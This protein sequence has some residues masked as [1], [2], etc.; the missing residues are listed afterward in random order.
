MRKIWLMSVL[1]VMGGVLLA[2]TAC[3]GAEIAEPTK[4]EPAKVEAAGIPTISTSVSIVTLM[5]TFAVTNPNDKQITITDLSYVLYLGEERVGLGKNIVL[6][7]RP[8]GEEGMAYGVERIEPGMAGLTAVQ[9]LVIKYFGHLIKRYIL[10]QTLTTEAESTGLGSNL[11]SVHLDTYLQIVR[12]DA[13]NLEETLT[14]DLV[15]VLKAFNFP[16][17]VDVPLRF[18]IET[19]LADVEAKLAGARQAWDMGCK[20]KEADIMEAI[21]M[22]SPKDDDIVLQDPAAQQAAMGIVPG[23]EGFG[24]NG[25]P[26][27]DD[28]NPTEQ[29]QG[30]GNGMF[31]GFEVPEAKFDAAG[32]PISE[33]S[34]RE[35][36]KRYDEAEAVETAENMA[37]YRND[38]R[39]AHYWMGRSFLHLGKSDNAR[40]AF[41]KATEKLDRKRQ[42]RQAG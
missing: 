18:K 39:L 38:L 32:E 22:E 25:Q 5:P 24:G 28:S 6:V 12:Y 42:A 13:I 20:L 26:G 35:K 29:Q 2:Q 31:K 23:Q 8:M 36:L 1:T 19:E 41:T 10:G 30:S 33:D 17:Y 15:D 7:P 37:K 27:Q 3:A 14:T 4:V 11:A 9:D 21:G 34:E 40:I 16:Q